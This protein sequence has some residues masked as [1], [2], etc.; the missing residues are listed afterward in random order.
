MYASQS[1][2]MLL[3]IQFMLNFSN[4]LPQHFPVLQ[5]VDCEVVIAQSPDV[6]WPVQLPFKDI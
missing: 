1:L 6:L 5:G 3:D 2:H 4:H